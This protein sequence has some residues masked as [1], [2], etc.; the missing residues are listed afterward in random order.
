MQSLGEFAVT[1][2]F[3]HY[4]VATFAPLVVMIAMGLTFQRK[5][6]LPPVILF[7]AIIFICL[8]QAFYSFGEYA[9]MDKFAF[10][11]SFRFNRF[12]IL[13]PLLWVLSFALALQTM[14]NSP[15]LKGLVMPFLVAQ[16]L[17]ALVGND[18][19]M[20][21]YRAILGRQKFPNYQ[22]YMAK[23]QFNDIKKYIG[24]PV[25]SYYVASFGISPSIAQYNGMYTL[26][27][28][29]SIYDIN[30][31]HDFRRIFAGEIAKSKDLQ[32]YYDGW[33][34]RCYI[35]SSELGIKHQSFNCSKYDHRSVSHLDFNREGFEDLGGR[36]II[37][38]VEIKNAENVGLHLEKVFTDKTSWWDIYLYSLKK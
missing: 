12:S 20:H 38:G 34:N 22:N 8:F 29:L 16:L 7:A 15:L 11:K 27:G 4:H 9:L 1:F 26:D 24:L 10:L 37:S 31:K 6:Y 17:I 21:D 2:F 18:E 35:F 13:L 36:Y 30:Y 14:R 5:G 19:L 33:G 23:D 25:D 3:V 32:Q 28:L